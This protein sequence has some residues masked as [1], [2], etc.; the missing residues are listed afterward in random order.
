MRVGITAGLCLGVSVLA[1]STAVVAAQVD[2]L[3][4][5]VG[6][7]DAAAAKQWADAHLAASQKQIDALLAVKGTRTVENTLRPFDIAQTELELAGS[8]GGLLNAAS[9]KKELRD[10]GQE[11]S[12]QVRRSDCLAPHGAEPEPRGVSGAE[13][14]GCFPCEPGHAL[15]HAPGP[16]GLPLERC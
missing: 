13:G 16:A 8:G 12:R 1:M 11:I 3:H 7:H 2:P 14:G 9:P 4:V 5:W 6:V 10:A 15:L